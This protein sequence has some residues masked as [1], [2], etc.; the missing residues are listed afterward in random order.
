L[1]EFPPLLLEVSTTLPTL[2]AAE[3]MASTL[4][5]L[6]LAACV[7]ITGPIQSIYRWNGQIH[8]ESEYSLKIKTLEPRLVAVVDH[9]KQH[10]P[11]ELPEIVWRTVSASTEYRAWVDNQTG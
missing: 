2:A 4:V 10:H 1:T 9:L 11:Y 7:Q 5:E 8:K 3:G 6:Q